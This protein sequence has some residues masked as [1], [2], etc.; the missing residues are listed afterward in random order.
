MCAHFPVINV[1]FF[2]LDCSCKVH[3]Y[4]HMVYRVFIDSCEA[5]FRMGGLSELHCTAIACTLNAQMFTARI[6]RTHSEHLTFLLAA[7]W[8]LMFLPGVHSAAI[9][10]PCAEPGDTP[11]LDPRPTGCRDR[12]PCRPKGTPFAGAVATRA[13]VAAV[14][15]A[16]VLRVV[17][18][19]TAGGTKNRPPCTTVY[20]WN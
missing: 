17:P 18:P 15:P 10:D 16:T 8:T 2:H 1:T 9:S 3:M 13:D 11:P 4:F 5:G 20:R 6:C 7:H 14:P 19:C 12:R